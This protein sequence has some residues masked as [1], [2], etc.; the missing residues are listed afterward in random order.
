H[1]R[2]L[3]L[4]SARR[5]IAASSECRCGRARRHYVPLTRRNS[6]WAA[7]HADEK[8]YQTTRC[9]SP[10]AVSCPVLAL[11]PG[12]AGSASGVAAA[13]LWA[14]VLSAAPLSSAPLSASELSSAGALASLAASGGPAS[15]CADRLGRLRVSA[16]AGAS[17]ARAATASS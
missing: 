7:R 13:V 15:R 3:S 16:R 14:P 2:T 17:A 5:R 11:G 12:L 9:Q 8:G 1:E 4:E 6:L 10:A